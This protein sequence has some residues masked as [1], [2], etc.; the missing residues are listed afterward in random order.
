MNESN[1][2]KEFRSEIDNNPTLFASYQIGK[3]KQYILEEGVDYRTQ[4]QL[5]AWE[6]VLSLLMVEKGIVK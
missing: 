4:Q 6:H 1:T 2:L 5:D 3:L